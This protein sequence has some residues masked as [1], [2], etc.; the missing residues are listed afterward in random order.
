M[1]VWP[2]GA[3]SG[4]ALRLLFLLDGVEAYDHGCRPLHD[5]LRTALPSDAALWVWDGRNGGQRGWCVAPEIE[6][7]E[8]LR[9]RVLRLLDCQAEAV[10]HLFDPGLG[11]SRSTG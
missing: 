10:A 11:R 9:P 8:G 3:D 4:L 7:L 2:R 5:A 6:D 1:P